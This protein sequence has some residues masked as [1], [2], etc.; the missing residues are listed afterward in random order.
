MSINTEAHT[1]QEHAL[2]I[3]SVQTQSIQ[4]MEKIDNVISGL[5]ELTGMLKEYIV[6]HDNLKESHERIWAQISA[7]SQEMRRVSDRQSSN[8]AVID[9]V[10]PLGQRLQKSIDDNKKAI[11]SLQNTDSANQPIIDGVRAMNAKLIWLVVAAMMSP[12][13][14]GVAMF[15]KGVQ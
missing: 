5:G 1:L 15:F 6:K 12:V 9:A 7:T 2:R 3:A 4:Q 10:N 11:V 14:I 13:T 8:Q